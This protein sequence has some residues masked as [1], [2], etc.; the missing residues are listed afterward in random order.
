[1]KPGGGHGRVVLDFVD[2][3]SYDICES[4]DV[5]GSDPAWSGTCRFYFF[6]LPKPCQ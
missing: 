2:P 5:R 4:E 6:F 3:N 1:M